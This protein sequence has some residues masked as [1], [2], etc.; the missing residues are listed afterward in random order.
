MT[1]LSKTIWVKVLD[2]LAERTIK[3]TKQPFV[4]L[5][6]QVCFVWRSHTPQAND[7]NFNTGNAK[8]G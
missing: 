5:L 7:N 6:G 8:E 4:T 1:N 2:T 3:K